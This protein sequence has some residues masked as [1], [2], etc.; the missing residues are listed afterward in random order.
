MCGEWFGL[1]S[2]YTGRCQA[3]HNGKVLYIAFSHCLNSMDTRI[4]KCNTLCVCVCCS[5]SYV[6]IIWVLMKLH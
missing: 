5:V 4:K 6:Y 2:V 3:I 1:H